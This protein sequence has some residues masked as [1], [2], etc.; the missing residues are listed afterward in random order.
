MRASRSIG[1]TLAVALLLTVAIAP[2]AHA[3]ADGVSGA[4]IAAIRAGTS[5][6]IT[7]DEA[8][9]AAAGYVLKLPDGDGV[10]YCI[11]DPSAGGMGVHYVNTGALTPGFDPAQPEVLVYEPGPGGKMHLVA[12][13][14]VVFKADLPAGEEPAFLGQDLEYEPGPGEP[15]ANRYGL[16]AFYALHVWTWKHNPSGIFEDYNPKVHCPGSATAMAL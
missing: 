10:T 4:D 13:E 1:S 14:F 5:Q 11:D 9:L 7:A 6:F 8:E 2:A 16:P 3:A 15:N 12:V